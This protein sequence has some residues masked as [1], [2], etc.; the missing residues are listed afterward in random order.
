MLHKSRK[1]KEKKNTKKTQTIKES[2]WN[3]K[4]PRRVKATSRSENTAE[5]DL[6]LYCRAIVAMTALYWNKTGKPT[7]QGRELGNTPKSYGLLIVS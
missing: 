6:K 4:R 7:E 3:H 1:E 2:I 5:S